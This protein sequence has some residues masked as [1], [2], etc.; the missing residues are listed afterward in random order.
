MGVRK[1]FRSHRR[2]C[3][4]PRRSARRPTRSVHLAPPLLERPLANC[5]MSDTS[6]LQRAA[7]MSAHLAAETAQPL[8]TNPTGAPP[9]ISF[10]ALPSARFSQSHHSFICPHVVFFSPLMSPSMLLCCLHLT[11]SSEFLS[12]HPLPPTSARARLVR[13]CHLSLT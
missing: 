4:A 11:P 7:I 9:P 1:P 5:L 3:F 8:E 10:A 2:P 12:S 6:Y 13:T